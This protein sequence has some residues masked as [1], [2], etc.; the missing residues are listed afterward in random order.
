[1]DESVDLDAG[2]L[3]PRGTLSC[4]LCNEDPLN[5][6]YENPLASNICPDSFSSLSH[7]HG[8]TIF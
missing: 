3:R 4:R 6:L 8:I 1:M 5:S 2:T 7:T